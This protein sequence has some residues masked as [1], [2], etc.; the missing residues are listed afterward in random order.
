M[1]V[2]VEQ[3]LAGIYGDNT[4]SHEDVLRGSIE[5]PIPIWPDNM[6]LI[7]AGTAAFVITV[8]PF[9]AL[10]YGWHR[11]TCKVFAK[12]LAEFEKEEPT[13]EE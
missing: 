6:Q 8:V 11:L 9:L 4:I 1:G 13:Q 2:E 7:A 3:N 10:V 5:E 12:Q